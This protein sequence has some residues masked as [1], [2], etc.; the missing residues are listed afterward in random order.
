VILALEF[1]IAHA[2]RSAS[3]HQRFAA[4]QPYAHPVIGIIG[5]IRIGILLLVGPY[6]SIEL[7]GL[8]DVRELSGPPESA[9]GQLID[10]LHTAMASEIDNRTG[11]EHQALDAFAGKSMSRHAA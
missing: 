2:P 1:V 4:H 10:V 8:G 11:I 6:V 9:V 7:V 5:I 3:P